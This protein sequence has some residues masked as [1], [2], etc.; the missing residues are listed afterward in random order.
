MRPQRTSLFFRW[1]TSTGSV[2]HWL[3][4]LSKLPK[5]GLKKKKVLIFFFVLKFLHYLPL[6]LLN[7]RGKNKLLRLLRSRMR[8]LQ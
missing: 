8:Q 2:Y 6:I 3:I 5:E 4:F 7:E 1:K